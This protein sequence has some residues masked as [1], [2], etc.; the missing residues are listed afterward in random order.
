[1]SEKVLGIVWFRQ[2]L[3]LSDNPALARACKDCDVVV[4]V[5][6]DDPE[7]QTVSR[8]GAAS[9]AWLHGSLSSL[10]QQL[11]DKGG[12]LYFMQGSSF[13]AL[14]ALIEHTGATRLYW[15]RCYDPRSIE[16][17]TR[18]KKALAE[19]Q[20]KTANALLIHEPWSVLK[21]DGTPYRVYTPYWRRSAKQLAEAPDALKMAPTPRKIPALQGTSASLSCCVA[22]SD[23]SLMPDRD[24]GEQMMS[25][26]AV[27]EKAAAARLKQFLK[28]SVQQYQEGRNLPGI[29]GTSKMSPHLHFGEIS[30]RQV[31]NQVLGDRKLSSLAPDEET[32][33]KELFWREFAYS[34]I[35]HYPGII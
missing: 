17:D 10:Q 26:W 5:F 35:Y 27:G 11:Q 24:W 12:E 6:I 4:P 16:R 9:R 23:L 31:L 34:L 21:D 33:V 13:E 15:N 29:E 28:A 25:H 20:P 7:D 18:I 2:D 3:R 22:L 32:F 14:H 19:Q 8:L 1:M 30:P